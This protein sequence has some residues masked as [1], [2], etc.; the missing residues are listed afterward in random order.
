[1]ILNSSI[2]K[3]LSPNIKNSN[4]RICPN[5]AITR[6]FFLPKRSPRAPLGPSKI[7]TT[8]EPPTKI[9]DIKIPEFSFSCKYNVKIGEKNSNAEMK[10]IRNISTIFFLI[11]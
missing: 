7:T 9:T 2:Q 4:A 8:N 6:I 10:L 3:I 1:M 11:V 5:A